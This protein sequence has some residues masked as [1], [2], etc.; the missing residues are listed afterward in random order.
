FSSIFKDEILP[1]P[2]DF[3]HNIAINESF[4]YFNFDFNIIEKALKKIPLSPIAGPDMIPAFFYRLFHRELF[5]P[6]FII[7]DFCIN[8]SVLPI[9]LKSSNITVL[10]KNKGNRDNPDNYRDISILCNSIKPLE[11][12]INDNIINFC[13]RNNIC[14]SYQHSFL[15]NRSTSSNLLECIFNLLILIRVIMLI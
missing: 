11:F 10:Y 12:L 7:Y 8:F 15:K 3:S 9:I 4:N 13:Y 5:V 14:S 1:I 6:L 2:H